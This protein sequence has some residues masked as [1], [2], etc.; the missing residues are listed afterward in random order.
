MPNKTIYIRAADKELWEKAEE[1][2]GDSVSGLLADAL[3][4]Y[5][6]EEELKK[7]TNMETIEVTLGGYDSYPRNVSF[8][9]RTLIEPHEEIS[10][11]NDAV[12]GV[13]LTKRG[14]IAVLVDFSRDN[15]DPIFST[16]G[17]FEEAIEAEVPADIIAM[18]RAELDPDYVQP[19]D[20]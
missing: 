1:L 6:E 11:H 8:V 19:L 15:I 14:K 2:A 10:H 9:G 20:I 13:W 3:R 18:A 17:S 4:R 16:Y 7:E 5:V 12:F